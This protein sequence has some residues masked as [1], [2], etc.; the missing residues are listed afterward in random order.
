M[1]I[2][3][4]ETVWI[5]TIE[6]NWKEWANNKHTLKPVKLNHHRSC[7]SLS[8][9]PSHL[10]NIALPASEDL[11]T[12]IQI[13]PIFAASTCGKAPDQTWAWGEGEG[14]FPGCADPSCYGLYPQTAWIMWLSAGCSL[15]LWSA[16][17]TD[18]HGEV[19]TWQRETSARVKT[20]ER[21]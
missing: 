19:V 2:F 16:T 3:L 8:A 7:N 15:A 17:R 10:N 4:L 12:A 6:L 21:N 13:N 11:I 5:I 14:Q 18:L 20:T 9:A 1:L